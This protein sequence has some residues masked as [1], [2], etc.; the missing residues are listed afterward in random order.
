M[1]PYLGKGHQ[2][3]VNNWY[4]GILCCLNICTALQQ[5]HVGQRRV[6]MRKRRVGMPKMS[7]KLQT[8]ECTFR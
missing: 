6:G 7:E 5:M 8:G 2:L 1:Q 3:F 4:Y